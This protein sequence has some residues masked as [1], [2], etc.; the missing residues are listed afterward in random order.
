MAINKATLAKEVDGVTEF[1]YPK[2]SADMVEY[3][4]NQSVAEKIASME[5]SIP[6]SIPKKTSDLTNDSGFIKNT[7]SDLVN[8]YKK[9]ETYTQAEINNLVGQIPKFSIQVVSTLPTTGISATT[10]YLVKEN[11][12]T[13]NLYTEYIYV[14][15]KWEIL[16]SQKVDLTGYAKTADIPTKTSQ[17]TNDSNFATTNDLNT[18][19]SNLQAGIPTKLSQ[20]TND[21]G[22]ITKT[23]TDLVNYYDK[24]TIDG[25]F[26][27]L[28]SEIYDLIKSG[29]YEE[30]I[31]IVNEEK[32]SDNLTDHNNNIIIANVEMPNGLNRVIKETMNKLQQQ[33]LDTV[34]AAI[35]TC[36][37]YTKN[38]VKEN[39]DE[40]YL[41][42]FLYL[43]KG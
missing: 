29:V 23:V 22:F 32:V 26:T 15:S 27:S 39:L 25:K 1:I 35:R 28:S 16:G 18:A 41:N 37:Q 17:L 31:T 20:F 10:V 43:N 38:Y 6:D 2:T 34:N 30:V 36:K 7:V 33:I 5:E 42:S 9:S 12:D 24:T 3:D 19:I 21:P 14:N 4:A 8:Y 11:D 40:E 13:G